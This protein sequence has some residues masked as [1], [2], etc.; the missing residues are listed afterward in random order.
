MRAGDRRARRRAGSGWR[1]AVVACV[2]GGACL[3]GTVTTAS[4]SS[5]WVDT[6]N[7]LRF[8]ADPGEVNQLD[9]TD[10][11]GR[12]TLVTDP[13]SIISVGPGC[14]AL[15]VHQARCPRPF[16]QN[17]AI[18][19]VDQDDSVLAVKL[20][21]GSIR[22]AGGDGNDTM[23]DRPLYATDLSG[24]PG[25]DAISV[26]ANT[27]SQIN[28]RG[29]DGNDSITVSNGAGTVDGGPGSDVITLTNISNSPLGPPSAAY[30]GPGHDQI[31]ANGVT[32]VS[33]LD[34]GDGS[35]LITTDGLATAARMDGG[36]HKD[37][38]ITRNVAGVTP[39]VYPAQINGGSDADRIDGGGGNDTI[40]C[41]TGF[42]SYGFY[43][44]D[45]VI[46]CEHPF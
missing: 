27:G 24:G 9:T 46:G 36:A 45:V 29:D 34:G 21:P 7:T 14:R 11:G 25:D 19:L 20:S 33:L 1:R 39:F 31:Y 32:A 12:A 8:S 2:V 44:G 43:A 5:L 17:L 35:D 10:A 41:G 40:D 28:A 6:S 18:D 16:N 4:A 3:L 26:V 30:G 42:D 13:G 22:I 23:A 37:R 38:I 15:T